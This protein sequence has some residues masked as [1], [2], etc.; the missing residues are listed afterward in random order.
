MT[1][2][3]GPP[4]LSGDEVAR[5]L[6]RAAEIDAVEART[7][8]GLDPAALEEAAQEVGL[9][10]AAVRRAVAELRAGA[11]PAAPTGRRRAER[12]AGGSRRVCEQRLV[13]RP[14]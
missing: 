3:G 1:Q 11:L 6:R 2:A 9:S 5:V 13:D 14:V 7:E 8:V 12:A 10:P 4:R